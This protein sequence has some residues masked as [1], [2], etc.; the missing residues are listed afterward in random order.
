[1]QDLYSTDPTQGICPNHTA[2]KASIRQQE[3]DRTDHEYLCP[4]MSR[5]S[6]GNRSYRSSVVRGVGY[7]WGKVS[8]LGQMLWPIPTT[9]HDLDLS[10]QICVLPICVWCTVVPHAAGL[11]LYYADPAQASHNCTWGTRWFRS[12]S[13]WS[14]W[15]VSRCEKFG[16]TRARLRICVAR[17]CCDCA[18]GDV[19]FV[20]VLVVLLLMMKLEE[21]KKGIEKSDVYQGMY[22]PSLVLLLL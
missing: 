14:I 9:V 19:C 17:C 22:F 13:I 11:D 5:S 6:S 21:K 16:L 4:E 10:R 20:L 8:Q 7:C 15:S 18:G 1:M 3:L 2:Y 12:W